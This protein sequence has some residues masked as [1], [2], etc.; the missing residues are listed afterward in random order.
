LWFT[1]RRL[2]D[3]QAHTLDQIYNYEVEEN[4]LVLGVQA[5][6]WTEHIMYEDRL[7]YM[8]FPRLLAL[9]ELAWTKTENMNYD[10]FLMRL[11]KE[12]R[13]L[14]KMGIYYYDVRIRI[15]ILNRLIRIR[16]HEYGYD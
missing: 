10:N 11:D 12:Y 6:L 9:A 7:D 15:T 13:Y 5:N 4:A 2:N 1:D 8:A 14:D 3:V 16:Y